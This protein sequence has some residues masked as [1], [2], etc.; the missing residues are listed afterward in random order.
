MCGTGTALNVKGFCLCLTC[1]HVVPV[2]TPYKRTPVNLLSSATISD[3][4]YQ[5]VATSFVLGNTMSSF[6]HDVVDVAVVIPEFTVPI[7]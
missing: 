6:H 4:K 2:S 1:K 7:C 5:K 3:E